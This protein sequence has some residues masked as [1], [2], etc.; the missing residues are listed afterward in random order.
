MNP[1][2]PALI[3]IDTLGAVADS[4]PLTDYVREMC[5]VTADWYQKS[6]FAPPWISYLVRR[7][8]L[9]V[10]VCGF[11]G[12][13]RDG[14]VEIAYHTFPD[15][16]GQGVATWVARRMVEISRVADAGVMI[17]AQTLPAEN[18]STA[19][20]KKVGF[21]WRRSLEHPEDGLVWEWELPQETPVAA[22]S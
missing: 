8:D 5:R 14:R 21:V 11:K 9:W 19:L 15:F 20:L 1:S 10:G 4:L 16:E 13:P 18:A 3:P 12:G 7:G 17:T 22:S 2:E 6:G